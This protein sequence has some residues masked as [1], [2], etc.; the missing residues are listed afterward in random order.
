MINFS[1]EEQ[2]VDRLLDG[3]I[4][5]VCIGRAEMGPRALCN[6][7][8]I[9]DPR[10]RENIERINRKIKNR[11]FWMPFAPVIMHEYQHEI[12]ENPKQLPSPH[13]TIG[14]NTKEGKKKMPAAVHQYDGTARPLILEKDV[15]ERMWNVLNLFYKKTGMPALVNTSFNLHGEPI[16]NSFDDA[17]H[18]FNNSGL[19]SLW[20]DNHIID[21]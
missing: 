14:F 16:V 13:M 15:N 10:S 20:L 3:K 12:L 18:V 8:I 17:I 2:I 6:R 21:K 9:A 7:S 4:I 1:S 19:D 11:D 5:A